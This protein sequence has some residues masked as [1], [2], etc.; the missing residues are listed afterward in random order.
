VNT[1]KTLV[2]AFHNNKLFV[3]APTSIRLPGSL[4]IATAIDYFVPAARSPWRASK[5]VDW[6]G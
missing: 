1:G 6:K 4:R 2:D 3:H 5:L